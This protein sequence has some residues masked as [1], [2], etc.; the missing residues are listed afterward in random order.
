MKIDIS[1]AYDRLEWSFLENMLKKFDFNEVWVEFGEIVPQRGIRKGG[2]ISPYL[3]IMCA[4]GLSSIIRR[5]KLIYGCVVARGAPPVS[6]LLF[7]D[8]CYFFFKET[9]QE[10]TTMRNI[11]RRYENLSG[12]SINL[13][14]S[15]V[16]F[17]P[18]TTA[19]S[20]AQV[21]QELQVPEVTSPSTYLGI[22]MSIGR[23]KTDVF[24]FLLDRVS[25]KIKG[26]RH[27]PISRGGKLVLLKT[28]AQT[29]PNFWMS[30]LR[31]PQKICM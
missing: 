29:I 16:I 23:K 31:V 4:E 22:P 7:A 18:N 28:A 20:R 27:K 2:P 21:C 17:S 3:Y 14:K 12:Q 25:H 11:L 24:K 10:A 5:P 15:T 6:Y 19:T 13:R 8:D 30:L 9:K 1:R 26:W